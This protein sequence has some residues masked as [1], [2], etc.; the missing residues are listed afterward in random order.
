MESGRDTVSEKLLF[1][2][3]G[4]RGTTAAHAQGEAQPVIRIE[5]L[6]IVNGGVTNVIIGGP[7]PPMPEAKE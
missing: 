5:S 3:L 2:L 6:T 7:R 4:D 1:D